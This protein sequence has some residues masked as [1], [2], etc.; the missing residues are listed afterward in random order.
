M[1]CLWPGAGAGG[2]DNKML[3]CLVV[4]WPFLHLEDVAPTWRALALGPG[5]RWLDLKKCPKHGHF[6]DQ[7]LASRGRFL[8]MNSLVVSDINYTR[9][10]PISKY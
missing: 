2:V 5:E 9:E 1:I 4:K 6:S 7:V 10:G 3:L 8:K